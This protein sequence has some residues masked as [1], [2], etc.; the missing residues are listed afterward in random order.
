[1]IQCHCVGSHSV[2]GSPFMTWTVLVVAASASPTCSEV[3]PHWVKSPPRTRLAQASAG[4]TRNRKELKR[5]RIQFPSFSASKKFGD[6]WSPKVME[7][8][9]RFRDG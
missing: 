9:Q 5:C 6:D 7:G 4:S 3:P 2:S 8:H 1:M